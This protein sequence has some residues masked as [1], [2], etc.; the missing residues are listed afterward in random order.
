[1]KFNDDSINYLYW[2]MKFP[3]QGLLVLVNEIHAKRLLVLVDEIHAKGLLV[4]VDE[5]HAE[6]NV[7]QELII[8]C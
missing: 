8:V 4:L 2:L 1:M 5:I 7:N 6:G 3:S